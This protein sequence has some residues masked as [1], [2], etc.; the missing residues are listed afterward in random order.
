MTTK[1]EG[2]SR[3]SLGFIAK[4]RVHLKPGDC[5]PFLMGILRRNWRKL[6]EPMKKFDAEIV[7]EF[8]SNAYLERQKRHRRKTMV[9]GRWIRY[10]PQAIDDLLENPYRRQE[11]QCHYLRLCGRKKG[12]NSR[13]VATVVC[14][15][16]KGYQLTEAGKETRI[17]RRDMRTLAQVWLTFMMANVMPTGHVSDIKVTKSNLLFSMM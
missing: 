17:R 11:E 16:G 10:N 5:D 15:P 6:A 13:K 4:R 7:R 8:Y 2:M 1:L 14:M 12:F 9:R 3:L